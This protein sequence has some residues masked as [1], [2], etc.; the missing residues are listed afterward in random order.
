[1]CIRWMLGMWVVLKFGLFCRVVISDV[2]LVEVV[3]MFWLFF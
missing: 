2:M 1:M 3:F